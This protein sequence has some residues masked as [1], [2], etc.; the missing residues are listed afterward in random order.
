M[1]QGYAWTCFLFLL[2]KIC[3][4]SIGK[5]DLGTSLNERR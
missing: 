1:K 2:N 4:E 3:K 5:E